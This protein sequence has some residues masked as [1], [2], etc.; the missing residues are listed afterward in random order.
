MTGDKYGKAWVQ[1]AW[2]DLLG[3]YLEASLYAWQLYPEALAPFN[4]GLW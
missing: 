4:R 1:Q 2:R 3:T